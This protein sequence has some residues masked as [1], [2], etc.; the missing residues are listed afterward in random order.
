MALPYRPIPPRPNRGTASGPAALLLLCG[1]GLLALLGGCE[2][3]RPEMPTFDSAVVIPLGTERVEILDAL[4]DEDYLVQDADGG[5]NF[6]I[7]G[8][9]DTMDFD[10]ELATDI[11]AQTIDQGLGDFELAALDPISYGF[12]LGELWTPAAGIS[13]MTAPVPPFPI[14]VVS[15]PQDVP[16]VE[17]AWLTA[18]SVTLT[19]HNGLPVPISADSGSDRIQLLLQNPATGLT[20]AGFQFDEIAPGAS[21]QRTAN[22]A[23]MLLPGELRVQLSGGSPGSGGAL[24]TVSG[25]DAI[26]VGAVFSDLVVSQAEAVIGAQDFRLRFETALPADYEIQRAVIET[27][28][29][30]LSLTNSMPIPCVAVLSWSEVVDVEGRPLTTTVELEPGASARRALDFAGRIVDGGEAALTALTADVA[31]TTPGSG[32]TPVLLSSTDGLTA[33]LAD[34]RI[35]FSSVTGLV[36]A[37]QVVLEPLEEQIDLPDELDGLE[38]TAATMSLHITNSSGLAGQVD[39]VLTGISA[40]GSVRTLSIARDI[41]PTVD[42]RSPA[43]TTIVLDQDN[44][45][46]IDFLNNLPDRISLEGDVLV[47]GSAGTV[48]AADYAIV[49]WEI[50]APVEVVIRDATIETDPELLDTDEDLRDL[51][52]D[53]IRGARL[54]TEI[55]NH[56]PMGVEIH[57]LAGPDTL[58]LAE[59]PL[60]DIGPLVVAAATVDPTTHVVSE[61]VVSQPVL[62]LTGEQAR[63]FAQPDLFTLIAVRLPSSDGQPVRLMA[64]DYL[65]IR[66]TVRIEYEVSDD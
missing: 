7:E 46:L 54:E 29:V 21:Q 45:G 36:P 11:A 60:V 24:V 15:S 31:I 56:L 6:F 22:L 49:D 59:A 39:L 23:G 28:S 47:G 44:S 61:P 40:T 5:V 4:D 25:A 8:D 53:H 13:H 65:E 26:S 63:V 41:L 19:V 52:K 50:Q 66:G 3:N 20:V 34:G 2:L 58:T 16:D 51:I 9:A 17:S 33:E 30:D 37:E 12:E 42:T 27:G 48:H 55:L 18:G 43:T 62:D 38:L 32:S 57:V 1:P 64:S 35:A 10:F 14:D